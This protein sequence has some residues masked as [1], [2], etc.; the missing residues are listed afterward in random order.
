MAKHLV[1]LD[2]DALAG[3]RAQLGTTTIKDTVNK[4]LRAA[5]DAHD[6]QIA[7]ALDTLGRLEP[8]DR[9]EAWR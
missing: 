2:E 8:F 9:D 6:A 4:A 5:Q 3:A 1:D 7:D